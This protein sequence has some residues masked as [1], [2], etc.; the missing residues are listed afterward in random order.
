M[1]TPHLGSESASRTILQVIIRVVSTFTETDGPLISH[2]KH[3][4]Q[5]LEQQ[6]SKYKSISGDFDTVFLYE[7]YKTNIYPSRIEVVN[8]FK[9]LSNH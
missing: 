7:V 9:I 6:L 8:H 3:D 2:L 4:S 1:A 5:W